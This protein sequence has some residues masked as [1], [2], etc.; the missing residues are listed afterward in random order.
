M[1][2]HILA[3]TR[4]LWL[5]VS[6]F[7]KTTIGQRLTSAS[8]QQKTK[9]KKQQVKAEAV[10]SLPAAASLSTPQPEEMLSQLRES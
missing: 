2:Q 5:T 4:P 9:P 1:S 7:V 8:W 10:S 6:I 3:E